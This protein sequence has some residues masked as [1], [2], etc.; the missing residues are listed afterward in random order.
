M[1]MNYVKDTPLKYVRTIVVLNSRTDVSLIPRGRTFTAYCI[2]WHISDHY[3]LI[4]LSYVYGRGRQNIP[5]RQN[6]ELIPM[7][8]YGYI[9]FL[10]S[11]SPPS[12]TQNITLVLWS[13]SIPQP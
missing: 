13:Q 5:P 11:R 7:E 4:V 2:D 9:L 12:A 3:Q 8:V 6:L 1:T 10:C